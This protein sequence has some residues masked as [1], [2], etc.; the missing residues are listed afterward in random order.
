MSPQNRLHDQQ[1]GGPG[2]AM[3]R[4]KM[5]KRRLG[6]ILAAVV[7]VPVIVTATATP[8]LADGQVTWKNKA[9]GGCLVIAH[10]KQILTGSCKVAGAKWHEYKKGDA[11]EMKTRRFT[12]ELCLDSNSKGGVYALK[13]NGGNYQ[14]WYE[15]KNSQGWQ[16]KNKATGR[17][18][19]SSGSTGT[20]VRTKA[21]NKGNYQRWT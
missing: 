15:T 16:L 3:G 1:P 17:C 4:I 8:A 18:L 13:C 12:G 19:D 2:L 6:K 9:N 21:C 10:P 7:A 5:K 20:T 11:W 14:R